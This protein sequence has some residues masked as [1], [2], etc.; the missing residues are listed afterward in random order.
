MC[1]AVL[2][3]KWTSCFARIF[4]FRSEK[5]YDLADFS[6]EKMLNSAEKRFYVEKMEFLSM[7]YVE[8]L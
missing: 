5:V 3:W 2:K 8:F 4:E 7:F 6:P 1:I